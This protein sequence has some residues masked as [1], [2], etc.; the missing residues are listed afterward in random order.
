MKNRQTGFTLVEIAIV[1][2]IIGLLMGGVLKGQELINSAKV[3]NFANDF[4]SIP[5]FIYAYQDKYRALPGDDINATGHLGVTAAGDG[6]TAGS[7]TTTNGDGDGV[8]KGAWNSTKT[9]DESYLFWQ[10][11]RLAGLAPGS[12]DP[13][14][15]EYIPKNADGG[16]IGVTSGSSGALPI[17]GLRGTYFVCSSGILGKFAKQLDTMMDDGNTAGGSMMA[18]EITVNTAQTTGVDATATASIDDA[19]SYT[20]CM[21]L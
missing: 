19:K 12:T 2:V 13:T 15:T 11:V 10:H 20:V 8:I 17:K 14:A 16:I 6:A 9:S 3:K 21:G 5:M 18:A 7:T 4:R 1:L